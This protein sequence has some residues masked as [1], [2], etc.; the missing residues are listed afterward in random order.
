MFTLNRGLQTDTFKSQTRM[1]FFKSF[2]EDDFH[3]LMEIYFAIR[4]LENVN[5]L[6]LKNALIQ[7]HAEMV[8]EGKEPWIIEN[9]VGGEFNMLRGYETGASKATSQINQLIENAASKYNNKNLVFYFMPYLLLIVSL[10]ALVGSV[11]WK[12]R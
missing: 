2:D 3:I 7:K 1:D 12:L 10:I 5:P 8:K 4:I 9:Y 6:N 11:L